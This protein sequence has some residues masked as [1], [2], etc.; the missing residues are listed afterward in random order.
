MQKWKDILRSERNYR[1]GLI[2]TWQ[3]HTY[4]INNP[5]YDQINMNTFNFINATFDDLFHRFPTDYEF[6]VAF[7]IIEYNQS[8]TI[9]GQSAQNKLDYIGVMVQTKEYYEG[10]II[11]AFN[12]L[13]ARSPS[14]AETFKLMEKYYDDHDFQWVQRQ[15]MATDEY[16]NF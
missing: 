11:W 3:M 13:L 15:I 5:F 10:M 16:A 1:E 7:D 14:T 12:A 6:L 2:E 8:G 9:F 4:M